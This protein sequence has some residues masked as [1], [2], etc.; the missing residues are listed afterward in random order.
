MLVAQ[1]PSSA[2]AGWR[3][4]P[5]RTSAVALTAITLMLAW[6]GDVRHTVHLL[7]QGVC[8]QRP[9]HSLW[10]AG[11]PLP[12]DA[13][14]TGIYLGALAALGWFL[15]VWRG[16][17]SGRFTRATWAA[18]GLMVAAMAVDGFNSLA[19]DL[20]ETPLYPPAT[21]WRLLTGLLAGVAIGAGLSHLAA[22]SLRRRPAGGWPVAPGAALL[23][24][25]VTGGALVALAAS[26]LP[27]LAQPLTWL[28]LAGVIVTLWSMTAVLTALA[29]GRGWGFRSAMER[30]AT[31]ALALAAACGLLLAFALG[32][33]LLE[34]AFGPIRLP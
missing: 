12:V 5:W 31:L 6:P 16:A 9:S 2:S 30:D 20:G 21:S 23:A 26:G 19:L 24:P 22:I 1:A 15:L 14:M 34:Q 18:L 13:R 10:L 29:W 7:L 33:G 27:P 17:W 11:Q 25:L 28:V 8:A 3:G 32:R 4:A